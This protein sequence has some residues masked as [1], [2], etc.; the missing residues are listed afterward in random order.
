MDERVRRAV[1]N[2][3]GGHNPNSKLTNVRKKIQDK[4]EDLQQI[5]DKCAYFGLT[6]QQIEARINRINNRIWNLRQFLAWVRNDHDPSILKKYHYKINSI[7]LSEA[8]AAFEKKFPDPNQRLLLI[9]K[10]NDIVDMKKS[11]PLL[12]LRTDDD[13]FAAQLEFMD[14][15][16]VEILPRMQR[17][18]PYGT[19]AAQTIG[20]VGPPQEEDKQLFQN[21]RLSN[22]LSDEVC[23]REDGVEYVCEAILRGRRGEII[24]DIDGRLQGQRPAQFGKD[25]QLSLDIELQARIEDYLS[26]CQLNPH[27]R[28]PIA[29]V[30]IKVASGD[31]LALVSM[32]VF[33]LNQVRGCYS[34]LASDPNEPLRNR[35]INKQ[36]PPGSVIKPVI[37]IAGLEAGVISPDEI[38]SCPSRPA[39]KGWPNCWLYNKYHIG[40]DEKWVNNARNAIKGS[41]NIYFS[42]LADRIEPSVL[43]EWLLKFGYGQLIRF[44]WPISYDPNKQELSNILNRQLR[45]A[46]GIISSLVARPSSLGLRDLPA[47]DKSERRFFGMGQG[48]LRVTPLQVANAFAAIARGGVFKQPKL[49]KQIFYASGGQIQHSQGIDLGIS[50][51]TLAVVY[52]GMKAVVNEPGGTAYEE[53][54]YSGFAQQG[55]TVYG[56]TG[57]TEKPDNAW[58]AGFAKDNAGHSIAIAVVVE[59]GQHGSSDASPI[60]RDIIQFC[61]EA[62]YLQQI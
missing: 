33:D 45:Q 34:E 1:L 26:D 60:A 49:F 4:L 19:V 41:C 24:Y 17:F 48:N 40:H 35:A 7:P 50:P 22:Y 16:G 51:R 18:Y 57:S 56:K 42:R 15:K 44:S 46:R 62:G 29:C 5:I 6:R 11:W 9:S 39:P 36:Y 8:I 3:A 14:V 25:V 28:A 2:A 13:I 55:I 61:I 54:A 20:W 59:G 52:D 31:I 27:C 58:F 43:Q 47:L 38:I 30:V 23:G 10:V 37:L 32:P 21:D 12:Q 53:F